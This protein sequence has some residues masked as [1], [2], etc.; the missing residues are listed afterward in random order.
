MLTLHFYN[1]FP[2][3]GGLLALESLLARQHFAGRG[4]HLLY[5]KAIKRRA[6][7]C[8]CLPKQ[9]VSLL[10]LRFGIGGSERSCNPIVYRTLNHF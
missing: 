8:G 9:D 7:R 5:L 2:Q 6:R 4:K 1:P 3:Q 10:P